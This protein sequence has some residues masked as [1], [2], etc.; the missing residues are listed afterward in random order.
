MVTNY[1]RSLSTPVALN[2]HCSFTEDLFCAFCRGVRAWLTWARERGRL[3]NALWCERCCKS[4]FS[5][6]D[7][8][9]CGENRMSTSTDNNA[10]KKKISLVWYKKKK[11]GK[12]TLS[13]SE[14]RTV[15]LLASFIP[16]WMGVTTQTRL[17]L[18]G[19]CK[20]VKCSQD[21]LIGQLGI[22]PKHYHDPSQFFLVT[23]STLF[24]SS[25]C[26]HHGC[27]A[28]RCLRVWNQYF[29]A[30]FSIIFDAVHAFRFSPLSFHTLSV[31]NG[32]L[33]SLSP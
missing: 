26:H 9:G 16:G 30:N 3:N 17:L 13:K 6:S 4:R 15:L 28:P 5:C 29:L 14:R 32:R 8:I 1:L 19:V 23:F 12:N 7:P 21:A 22:P 25:R 31:P 18:Q 2:I 33:S 10:E 11:E 24:N 27:L 20:F